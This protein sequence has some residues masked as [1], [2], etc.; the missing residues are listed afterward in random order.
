M[1]AS[2][3]LPIRIPTQPPLHEHAW[4]VES[5]HRTSQGEIVYVR[6]DGCGVRRVDLRTVA[7]TPPTAQSR[8]TAAAR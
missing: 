7:G 5:A 3:T 4:S 8:T 6:C 1:T 2:Q